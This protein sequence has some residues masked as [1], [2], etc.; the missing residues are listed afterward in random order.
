M[1]KRQDFE[2]YYE[3]LGDV[4]QEILQIVALIYEPQRITELLKCITQCGYLTDLPHKEKLQVIRRLESP[5]LINEESKFFIDRSILGFFIKDYCLQN[6]KFDDYWMTIQQRYPVDEGISRYW[7]NTYNMDR[8]FRDFRIAFFLQD[9]KGLRK[10]FRLFDEADSSGEMGRYKLYL[11]LFNSHFSPEM[12]DL[13]PN[14]YKGAI[15]NYFYIY[16]SHSASQVIDYLQTNTPSIKDRETRVIL[17]GMLGYIYF[18][19]GQLELL[20]QLIKEK[21]ISAGFYLPSIDFLHGK[22]E[23]AKER[24]IS[25]IYRV[26]GSSKRRFCPP[27]IHGVYFCLTMIA[28]NDFEHPLMTGALQKG[29]KEK[30]P[31]YDILKEYVA[32]NTGNSGK[33][34]SRFRREPYTGF[35]DPV[36][37]LLMWLLDKRSLDNEN[38]HSLRTTKRYAQTLG[39]SYLEYQCHEVLG[40]VDKDYRVSIKEHKKYS[41]LSEKYLNL[42]KLIKEEEEWKKS[43]KILK[44]IASGNQGIKNS[45][46]PSER[47][48]WW[49]KYYDSRLSFSPKE[50]IIGKS[51]KWSKGRPVS[52]KRIMLSDVGCMSSIDKQIASCIS[53]ERFSTWGRYYETQYILDVNRALPFFFNHPYLFLHDSPKTPVELVKEIPQLIVRKNRRNFEVTLSHQ[54]KE[55]GIH[56]VRETPSRFKIVEVGELEKKIA[57]SIGENYKLVIPQEAEFELKKI[58]SGLSTAIT[59]H[60]DIE[61]GED[62]KIIRV[63]GDPKPH[64]H[65][66]PVGQGIRAEFFVRPFQSAGQYCKPGQGAK[67]IISEVDGK[68]KQA[69]RNLESERKLAKSIVSQCPSISIRGGYDDF[70]EFETPEECL[71]ALLDLQEV[72]DDIVIEWPE[73]ETLKLKQRYSLSDMKVAVSKADEWFEIDGSLQIDDDLVLSMQHLFEKVPNSR[74]IELDN[75][76]FIALTNELRQRIEELSSYSYTSK[77]KSRVHPLNVLAV[78]GLLGDVSTHADK[79]WKAQLGKAEASL[80][81]LPQLPSTFQAELRPYQMEGFEW[82]SRLANWEVGAC[83]ADDMGLGKTIQALAVIL[84]RAANGPTLVVAPAS[85]CMNWIVEAKKFAPTL[86]AALFG[87]DDRR[88][89][90]RNL[91]PFDLIVCSYGLLIHESE[92]LTGVQ[93]T[94]AVLDEAQAI[95]NFKA[96]R[97]Q[98]ALTIKSD[99]KM[100]TTGTPVENHLAEFWTLFSFIN[101]G[102]LG[103]QQEFSAKFAVPIERDRNSKVRNSLK[104]ITRPFLL[105]R[106]KAQVLDELPPKTEIS[107]SIEMSSEESAFYEAL[108]RNSLSQIESM[109]GEKSGAVHLRIL[110]ELT[111]LRRAC[112]HPAL[113]KEDAK[114]PSSKLSMFTEIVNEL[115]ENKHKVLVFSQFTSYLAIIQETCEKISIDYQYLD[116]STPIKERQKRIDAFQAGQ[117]DIFLISLKAGG[118]GLNLTAADYVIHMDPWWNPAVEDQA[119]DRAHRIGQQYPVTVYRFVTKG[120]IEEKIIELH[121]AKREL[122]DSLLD[123]ADISGKMSAEELLNLIK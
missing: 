57:V 7:P 113:I 39:C 84:E 74:F 86:N 20:A 87:P 80:L 8:I 61:G 96:K 45:Q 35:E 26:L 33:S 85:V 94:T 43:L 21:H 123:G 40:L 34:N 122:V 116:G 117:G 101:P 91:K 78:D 60:S 118:V 44:R 9:Q 23:E 90:L 32:A 4:E 54:V 107:L 31:I 68:K 28:T 77:G 38:L 46:G 3:V 41:L 105:R 5:V 42:G 83:L 50:Q 12:M 121:K 111:K 100:I 71:E 29:A 13:I 30:L 114:I 2:K 79:H 52:L 95:K 104:K 11:S 6:P 108:R 17:F 73:G 88:E 120:T 115:I 109:K 99:F 92:L 49:V 82:L 64:L 15:L 56:V 53:E 65:L 63:K 16:D 76:E 119:S 22:I 72:K 70:L 75:G 59:I 98:A 102:L 110:A 51:G 58:I 24:Y 48:V 37:C 67:T 69:I 36:A 10:T 55:K 25:E 1:M 14:E 18:E 97:T 19:R 106:R 112:C 66:L 47:L 62:S 27:G 103:S 89:T 93:W 81:F